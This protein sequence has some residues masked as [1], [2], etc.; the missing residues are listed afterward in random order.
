MKQ[1]PIR[2]YYVDEQYWQKY[3]LFV[4]ENIQDWPGVG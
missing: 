2:V 1:Q 3:I 4:G